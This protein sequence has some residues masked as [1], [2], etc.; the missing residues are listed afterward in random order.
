MAFTENKPVENA[1][2]TIGAV[3]WT[4]Q[5]LPQIV[6]SYR[7]KSTLGL[8]AGLMLWVQVHSSRG[9]SVLIADPN[10]NTLTLRSIWAIASWFLGS[11]IVVQR[12]SIPLQ[13]QPQLFGSLA[14]ISV[15]QC[16]YYDKGWSKLR[17]VLFFIIFEVLFAG[18]EAGSVFALWVGKVS[19]SALHHQ[20]R[21]SPVLFAAEGTG[22]DSTGSD[23]R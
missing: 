18:F 11:Y 2:G 15:A 8:S 6:K 20:H 19:S 22:L 10:T 21:A 4:I 3:L 7:S 12:L 23:R 1:L 14:A 13:I 9:I 16:L 17:A 5:I